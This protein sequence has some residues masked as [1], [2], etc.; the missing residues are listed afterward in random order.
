M[1]LHEETEEGRMKE[2]KSNKTG[3]ELKMGSPL[4]TFG[5]EANTAHF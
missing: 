4:I 2:K 3:R 5:K 1:K